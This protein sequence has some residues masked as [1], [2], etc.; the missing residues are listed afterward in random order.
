MKRQNIQCQNLKPR[1][2]EAVKGQRTI[3]EIAAEFEVHP[4][5]VNAWKKQLMNHPAEVFAGEKKQKEDF[6]Q[7]R[8]L[9]F[10]QI[11]QLKVEV[12]WLKKDWSSRLTVREKALMIDPE[13]PTLPIA[14]QCN[15]LDFLEPAIIERS[16]LRQR[17][18]PIWDSCD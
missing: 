13:H 17:A 1:F 12:D 6:E 2:T 14:K 7:E 8:D 4:T 11:G 18:K 5:Q 9:L 16:S 10:N 15:W 3:N